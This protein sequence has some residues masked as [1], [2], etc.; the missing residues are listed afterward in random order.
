M[1]RDRV[2]SGIAA[3]LD[4]GGLGRLE[5]GRRL[6]GELQ[7]AYEASEAVEERRHAARAAL[8][9]GD[10][11]GEEPGGVLGLVFGMLDGSLLSSPLF[12]VSDVVSGLDA[13]SARCVLFAAAARL[14]SG[15]AGYFS[16]AELIIRELSGRDLG[17]TPDDVRLLAAVSAPSDGAPDIGVTVVADK[18]FGLV[19]GFVERLLAAGEAELAEDVA[20]QAAGW[21]VKSGSRYSQQVEHE[22]RPAGLRDRA[23]ALA[24]YP[25][26]PRFEGPVGLADGW[27]LAAARWLGPTEDWPAGA[28]ELLAHC[29]QPAA[30]RP[31]NRWQQVCRRRLDAVADP[32]ALLRGLLGLLATAQ[33]ARFLYEGRAEDLLVDCNEPLLKG[34]LWAAGVL[35]PDWLPEMVR[36]AAVRCLRLSAGSRFHHTTVPG[37]KIPYACFHALALSG[38]DAALMALARTGRATTSRSVHRQ[39]EKLLAE[40]AQRRGL[41]TAALLDGLLPD[42]GLSAAGSAELAPG[43][44]IALDDHAGAVLTGPEGTMEPAGAAE[45]LADLRAT[46][47]LARAQ[48]EAMFGSLRELHVAD[49]T[50]NYLQH[51]VRAWLAA[52]LAWEFMPLPGETV[53]VITGFPDPA[54]QTVRVPEGE[55]PLPPGCLV[56]LVHPVLLDAAGLQ[57]LRSLAAGLRI[58][59]PVRQLWRET[60]WVSAAE[61][62]SGAESARYAGHVLRFKQCYGLARSRGWGGGFLYGGYDGG[63]DAIARKDYPRAGLR[64]SWVLEEA[65]VSGPLGPGGRYDTGGPTV[66]LCLTGEI[67]FSALD[68]VVPVPVPLADVPAEIFSETMRDI[69]LIVSAATVAN[70]PAWIARYSGRRLLDAYWDRMAAGGTDSLRA[71]RHELLA[72]VYGTPGD[73]YT[74]TETHLE[75]RG[76]L[77]SYRIDLAT[78]NVR[79]EP[80][81]KWL[82]FDS[83]PP[84]EAYYYA[85]RQMPALDDDEILQRIL[86]RA[87]V[88]ADD[89]LLASRKLL[90]QIRG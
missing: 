6:L 64:A 61:R 90:R 82:S 35:D 28:A 34:L 17:M 24:G 88:L 12:D 68:D 4:S 23:L 77:A 2:G 14:A 51:P 60:F 18:P 75:V 25:P 67:A 45:S 19:L 43:W 72:S 7:A 85:W 55:V 89:E 42:H 78:A 21:K 44:V 32:G 27:G 41:S 66:E 1:R 46:V 58:E 37:E 74:L 36:A 59:Q 38:S 71:G 62:E 69:D 40:T 80:S 49:F 33:P 13:E 11:A 86:V 54:R 48:L 39:L 20:A 84:E 56:R 50:E 57:R 29:V 81:G 26:P 73:R 79:M 87:A 16:F 3:A 63:Q 52:R 65:D 15:T 5:A 9:A 53:P 70:D 47:A 31:S 8:H 76:S 10:P 83:K 30:S 22:P